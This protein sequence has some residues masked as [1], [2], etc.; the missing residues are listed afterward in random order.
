MVFSMMAVL[1][2]A[3]LQKAL[4]IVLILVIITQV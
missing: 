4:N 2:A 1:V 3:V